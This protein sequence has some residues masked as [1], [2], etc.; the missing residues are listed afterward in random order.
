[1]LSI[2]K[3]VADVS[4]ACL[5]LASLLDSTTPQALARLDTMLDSLD[6]YMRPDAPAPK[7]V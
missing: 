2:D 6:Q 3:Q 7:K 1:V 4:G 5:S